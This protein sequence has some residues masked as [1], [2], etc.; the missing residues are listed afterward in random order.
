[1]LKLP[2]KL[3]WMLYNN[4]DRI[5]ADDSSSQAILLSSVQSK[6]TLDK[7]IEN[8]DKRK[9]LTVLTEDANIDDPEYYDK[10]G[11]QSLKGLGRL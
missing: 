7:F 6:E 10:E 3:F 11:L 4:I 1:M 8:C 2:V 5:I 9:G